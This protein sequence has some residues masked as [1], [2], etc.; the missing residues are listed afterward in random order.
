MLTQAAKEALILIGTAVAIALVV[1]AVRPDKI[2]VNPPAVNQDAAQQSPTESDFSEISIEDA[3]R[4]HQEKAAI[5]ADSRHAADFEAGHIQGAVHLYTADQEIWLPE[6]LATTDP[7]AVIIAYCDGEN[8]H[9]AP[10]LAELLFFNGFD[11]VRYLKNGW[12]RWRDGGF[13]IEP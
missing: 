7:T 2:G 8:C 4:L 5:F 10:A 9:L 6:F 13:P 12:T 1:Y 11:N 3:V